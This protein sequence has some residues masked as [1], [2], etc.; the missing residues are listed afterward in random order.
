[1]KK[2]LCIL[3]CLFLITGCSTSEKIVKP[4]KLTPREVLNKL[5][6]TKQNSFLMYLTMDDCYTCEEY[7][8]MI[9]EV[10]KTTPFDIYYIKLKLNETD[11]EILS[12]LSELNITI[13]D[14]TSLP[15]TFYFYQGSLL[16]ENKREGYIE[17]KDF[18]KWL[19]D[20]R[21][22]K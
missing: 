11:K 1:M 3:C 21:I 16:P 13:G 17:K 6:D 4:I 15:T 7:E 5:Q 8:K 9:K 18:T 2:I 14:Y 10:Q 20:L 22:L 12:D 19:K